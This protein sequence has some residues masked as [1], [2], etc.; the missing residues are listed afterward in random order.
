M[1]EIW[2][3]VLKVTSDGSN[4]EQGNTL[5]Y[6]FNVILFDGSL[7]D[8]DSPRPSIS[9]LFTQKGLELRNQMKENRVKSNEGSAS[10]TVSS[11]IATLEDQKDQ[12][13]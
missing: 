3:F 5:E 9:N 11:K 13:H 4:A 12:K 1:G 8:E 10:N 6:S 2:N 7:L